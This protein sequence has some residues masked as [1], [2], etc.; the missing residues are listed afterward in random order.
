MPN[1]KL[2]SVLFGDIVW[3]SCRVE[4]AIGQRLLSSSAGDSSSHMKHYFILRSTLSYHY[5]DP[6]FS[7]R[8]ARDGG[9]TFGPGT[10][11]PPIPILIQ[12]ASIELGGDEWNATCVVGWMEMGVVSRLG[13]L[14]FLQVLGATLRAL[15]V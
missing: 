12:V 4:T 6:M 10:L 3:P 14:L 11:D 13:D 2:R 9:S 5:A 15:S 8:P 7:L 1:S